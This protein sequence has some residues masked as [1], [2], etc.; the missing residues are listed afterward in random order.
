MKET[1]RANHLIKT[2]I[3]LLVVFILWTVAIVT[4]DKAPIGPEGS[5]VGFSGIN[6]AFHEFTG[7]NR[8]IYN[9]TDI[10]GLVPFVICGLLALL[11]LYQWIKR[12]N[13]LKVDAD[14]LACG[15][16]YIVII[17]SYFLFEKLSLNYRPEMVE[18]VME[19]SYPS[20]TTLVVISVMPSALL[21]INRRLPE[22]TLKTILKFVVA[23]FTLFMVF[24]RMFCGVHWLTDII[25][26]LLLGIGLF[27]VL[28]GVIQNLDSKKA[29]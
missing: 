13:L 18:G 11:G 8:T 10:L 1:F 19:A 5:I 4:V 28:K 7:L 21:E 26:G 6:S 29:E 23:L 27:F 24:S 17:I 12:K 9:L 25:G 22:G 16:F 15:V 2:G 20:S 3:I 14:I